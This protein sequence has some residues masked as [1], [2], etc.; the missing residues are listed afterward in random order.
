MA[1][2]IIHCVVVTDIKCAPFRERKRA[3]SFSLFSLDNVNV[4]PSIVSFAITLDTNDSPLMHMLYAHR[5]PIIF[6]Y[7]YLYLPKQNRE[8]TVAHTNNSPDQFSCTDSIGLLIYI[9]MLLARV[10]FWFFFRT[11]Y[12]RFFFLFLFGWCSTFWSSVFFSILFYD[13]A[14][15]CR[16]ARCCILLYSFYI[17]IRYVYVR[18]IAYHDLYVRPL[19]H[20][21]G[22]R[23]N[24]NRTFKQQTYTN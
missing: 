6:F 9:M 19:I 22:E 13:L 2:I 18:E 11:L 8:H 21:L 20:G 4:S 14:I 3:H 16:V 10:C 5:W 15:W 1:F 17:S 23:E 7:F 24:K 12:I